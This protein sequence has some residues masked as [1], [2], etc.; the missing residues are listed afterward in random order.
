MPPA[1]VISFRDSDLTDKLKERAIRGH[2]L[3]MTAQ[4]LMHRY[5]GV[6]QHA[7]PTLKLGEW[8]AIFDTLNGCW[9][10]DPS[11]SPRYI[12]TEVLDAPDLSTKWGIDQEALASYLMREASYVQCLAIVDAAERFLAYETH[13]IT[14]EGWRDV[15]AHIV[16]ADHIRD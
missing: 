2:S 5:M 9:M 13:D 7:L 15:I 3:G 10:G 12:G 11:W 14:G 4:R 8:C 6:V 16:G 1:P